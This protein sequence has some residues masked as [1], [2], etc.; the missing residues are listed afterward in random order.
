[1]R[2][3]QR[4]VSEDLRKKLNFEEPELLAAWRQ[5]VL[6]QGHLPCVGGTQSARRMQCGAIDNP[7]SD[8]LAKHELTRYSGRRMRTRGR[9]MV[10][11]HGGAAMLAVLTGQAS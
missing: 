2:C 9:L 10:H 1:M 11:H 6:P 5:R 4:I 3:M 8:C 7:A